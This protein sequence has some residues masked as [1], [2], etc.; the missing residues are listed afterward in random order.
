MDETAKIAWMLRTLEK[1]HSL[2]ECV[3]DAARMVGDEEDHAI[4]EQSRYAWASFTVSMLAEPADIRALESLR[5]FADAGTAGWKHQYEAEVRSVSTD[6][7]LIS[8][9]RES[10]RLQ[11]GVALGGG[12]SSAPVSLR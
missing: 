8:E 11:R 7:E 2:G 4:W 6:L 3:L 5:A 10:I 12:G 9:V 1:C